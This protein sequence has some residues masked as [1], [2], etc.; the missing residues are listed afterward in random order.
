[1]KCLNSTVN[2]LLTM[3]M[4][5]SPSDEQRTNSVALVTRPEVII[6]S[7]RPKGVTSLT[8]T[9]DSET[10]HPPSVRKVKSRTVN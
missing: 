8:V 7:D 1:M 2:Y 9:Y 6:K 5:N 10:L 4:H 3:N